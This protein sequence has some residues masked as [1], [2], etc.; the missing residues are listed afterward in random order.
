MRTAHY[1]ECP[2]LVRGSRTA[3]ACTL[4]SLVLGNAMGRFNNIDMAPFPTI[5]RHSEF[6]PLITAITSAFHGEGPR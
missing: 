1:Q 4:I 5:T 6:H 2:R 3:C